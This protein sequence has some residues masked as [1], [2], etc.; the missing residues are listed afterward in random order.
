MRCFLSS[1]FLTFPM[2]LI[3]NCWCVSKFDYYL[4]F[5]PFSDIKTS[6]N[7]SFL[8]PGKVNIGYDFL[9]IDFNKLHNP[10]FR[11]PS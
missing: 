5:L 2:M 3:M 7:G 11:S 9:R 8:D 6:K 10:L 1:L 4:N